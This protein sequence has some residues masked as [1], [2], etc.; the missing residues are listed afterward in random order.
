[1]RLNPRS[2]RTRLLVQMHTPH[3]TQARQNFRSRF[4]RHFGLL[5][6]LFQP[7]RAIMYSKTASAFVLLFQVLLVDAH[8]GL[9]ST[10]TSRS[11]LAFFGNWG[12][13]AIPK[14]PTAAPA[15]AAATAP[16][17]KLVDKSPSLPKLYGGWFDNTLIDQASAAI[18]AALKDGT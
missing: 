12:K 1:M 4:L 7:T 2:H 17:K 3:N 14:V 16:P 11:T 5:P 13:P 15:P 18:N 9:L 6:A 8:G 10:T